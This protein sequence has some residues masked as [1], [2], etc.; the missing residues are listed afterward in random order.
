MGLPYSKET[1]AAFDQVNPLVAKG[2][3]VSQS[4]NYIS[5]FLAVYQVF[6]VVFLALILATLLGLLITVNP[7]LEHERQELVT[8][9]MKRMVRWIVVLGHRDDHN[10]QARKRHIS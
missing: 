8:P 9:A 7:D 1:N 4:I 6:T 2:P 10:E 5:I 3:E